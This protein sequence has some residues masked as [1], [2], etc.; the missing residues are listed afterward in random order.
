[1]ASFV[2]L[3]DLSEHMYRLNTVFVPNMD[4]DSFAEHLPYE[5]R[6]SNNRFFELNK[7][8]P[9]V[10]NPSVYME[11]EEERDCYA[12]NLA[13]CR[14]PE[15]IPY[16]EQINV[17][18]DRKAIESDSYSFKTL[19]LGAELLKAKDSG[20]DKARMD[21]LCDEVFS[22][23][24]NYFGCKHYEYELCEA[25]LYIDNGFNVNETRILQNVPRHTKQSIGFYVDDCLQNQN[26]V[27]FNIVRRISRAV[28]VDDAYE[29]YSNA[30]GNRI[31]P[32]TPNSS[33]LNDEESFD[34]YDFGI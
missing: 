25:R 22:K 30:V 19:H 3:K 11:P 24:F 5:A 8:I 23:D 16:L 15:L 6:L 34:R 9:G 13:L 32:D 20:Y 27:D 14:L 2:Q 31:L 21:Y 4:I 7:A 28:T 17:C 12:N 18:L 29:A 33:E 1:M 26:P 10:L